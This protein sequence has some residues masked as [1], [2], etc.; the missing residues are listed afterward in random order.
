MNVQVVTK[1]TIKK[2][3]FLTASLFGKADHAVKV[4]QHLLKLVIV[5]AAL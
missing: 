4:I 5:I 1:N 2:V 3:Q